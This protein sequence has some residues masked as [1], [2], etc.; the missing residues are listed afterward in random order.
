VA[1]QVVDAETAKEFMQE[2]L[3]K[4]SPDDLRNISAKLELKAGVFAERLTPGRLGQAEP[5]DIRTVLRNVF[6][7]RRHAGGILDQIGPAQLAAT[8]DDLL[9]GAHPLPVRFERCQ[10][11]LAD[12]P[13]AAFDL[14]AELLHFTYP[15]RYWLWSRWMWDPRT[16]TG[17]LALVTDED[18][19]F[20]DDDPGTTYLRIGEAIA[21]VTE[22]GRASGFAAIGSGPFGVDVFLGCVYAVYMYTVL[23]LRM[24]QEFNRIVPEQAELV[25]RLLGVHRLEV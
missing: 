10:T 13:Q 6:S 19:D 23:R 14:P 4:V 2:T 8:F 7:T 17:S 1:G 18:F 22:T 15:D 5:D 21:F 25:Q 3:A 11:V 12:F 20:G 16:E 9:H 24:T